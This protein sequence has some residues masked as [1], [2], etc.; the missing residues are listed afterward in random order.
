M[1]VTEIPNL[2]TKIDDNRHMGQQV[3]QVPIIFHG[4]HASKGREHI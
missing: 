2:Q 4:F 3:C 1:N